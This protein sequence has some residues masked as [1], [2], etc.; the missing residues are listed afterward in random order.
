MNNQSCSGCFKEFK[1]LESLEFHKSICIYYQYRGKYIS[2]ISNENIKNVIILF[3]S[4]N[5]NIDDQS[6]SKKNILS[7]I[8]IKYSIKS[9]NIIKYLYN[10]VLNNTL[11][12]YSYID[13]LNLISSITYIQFNDIINILNTFNKCTKCF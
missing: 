8:K 13:V 9:D 10:I 1:S 2:N 11:E 5:L 12:S 7:N 6:L 4:M 3:N